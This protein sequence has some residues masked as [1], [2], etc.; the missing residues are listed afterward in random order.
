MRWRCQ[1][2]SFLEGV[3]IAVVFVS[4]YVILI[5]IGG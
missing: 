3:G 2:K 4:L 5:F 1:M